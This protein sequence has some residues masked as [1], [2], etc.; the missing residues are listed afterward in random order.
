MESEGRRGGM[1]GEGDGRERRSCEYVH[2]SHSRAE[3]LGNVATSIEFQTCFEVGYMQA[4]HGG[5]LP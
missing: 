2:V 4:L 3:G 1:E 5:P